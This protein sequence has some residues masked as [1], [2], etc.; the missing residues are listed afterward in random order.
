MK[1]P[2]IVLFDRRFATSIA[3]AAIVKKF[4]TGTFLAIDISSLSKAESI[5]A[6]T[7][8]KSSDLVYVMTDDN[9]FKTKKKAEVH[10][11]KPGKADGPRRVLG[12]WNEMTGSAKVPLVI[13][14]LGNIRLSEDQKESRVFVKNAIPT[15]LHDLEGDAMHSWSRLLTEPQDMVLLLQFSQNGQIIEDYLQAFGAQ[16]SST[17]DASELKAVQAKVAKLEDQKEE[18]EE[19]NGVN[20]ILKN[21]LDKSEVDLKKL[22]DE[23]EVA[24]KSSEKF[25]K[26][27]ETEKTEHAKT[28]AVLKGALDD[29]RSTKAFVAQLNR[30]LA[31][32]NE[33]IARAAPILLKEKELHKTTGD[34]LSKVN[35]ELK[36]QDKLV[37]E[38]RKDYASEVAAGVK[39][40]TS[41]DKIILEVKTVKTATD[42]K[43]TTDEKKISDLKAEVEK[44]KKGK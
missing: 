27:L 25:A 37:K 28:K 13:H 24:S 38:A 1:N 19:L 4:G 35:E 43:S 8:I 39:L 18:I 5:K 2:N 34:R 16:P 9:P 22:D 42:K 23:V 31:N 6:A 10:Y 30:D 12:V 44:L 14:Y 41:I 33:E 17:V 32:L 36:V 21:Q 29:A 20:D 26:D 40:Q 7:L 11:V 3:S 15:Y